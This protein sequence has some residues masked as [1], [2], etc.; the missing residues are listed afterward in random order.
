MKKVLFIQ[1]AFIG[2]AVLGTAVPEALCDANTEVQVLVRKGNEIFYQGNPKVSKVWIW[3]KKEKWKSWWLL[4]RAIRKEQLD[5]VFV[6]QRFFS[7]GLFTILSGAVRKT[8]YRKGW[9]SIGFDE[10][11]PHRW[12]NGVHEVDRLMDLVGVDHR[13]SP[14]VYPSE[15]DFQRVLDWQAQPYVTLSPSS[16]WATK[17]APSAVWEKV[18]LRHQRE[19]IYLLGGPADRPQLETMSA[20]WKHDHII[21]LAGQL[22]LLESAALMKGAKMNYVND[23]GPLHLCSAMNAPVTSFFCSTVPA[24]GF[25]PLSDGALVLES[26]EVLPCRPC[27]MH[28]HRRCPKGH[29]ACG[30]I[31]LPHE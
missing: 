2:D 6:A 19:V 21:I 23:S 7:M 15:H 24:F 11:I 25:G 12:G 3:D 5:E 30:N 1:T 22:S 13:V 4:L 17:Q 29:F 26:T 10:R 27:G 14:K 18:V 16:V 31:S 9:W 28:G 20:H 8:G